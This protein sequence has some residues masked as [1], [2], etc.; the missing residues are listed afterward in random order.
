MAE[1]VIIL[2]PARMAAT[3][4]PGKPLADI[5]GPADD[6]P[7][8]GPRRRGRRR[9]GVRRDRF[10]QRSPR[11]STKAG[12]RAV[13]T[14]PDHASGS[15]RIFEALQRIARP[16]PR[17][18]STCRATCRRSIPPISARRSRRSP[19]RRS[20]SR[21]SRPRSARR[22]ERT[23]PNVVKVVGTPVGAASRR[24]RALYFTR[25]TAP[26]GDGPLYHH[27]GLYAYRRAALERFVRLPPSPWSGARSSSNCA[28]SK[29]ACGSMSPSWR[30]CRS[31]SIRRTISKSRAPCWRNADLTTPT[32]EG[33]APSREPA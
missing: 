28:R 3:R 33:R 17:S 27:I 25:A 2:I 4:L 10:A 32:L 6:R 9:P 16:A 30:R 8:A 12:G 5:A 19:I 14:R 23:N 7:C 20:T 29:P 15:D 22:E 1:D 24:L 26:Y 18:S 21:P 31:A 11:R 13:M